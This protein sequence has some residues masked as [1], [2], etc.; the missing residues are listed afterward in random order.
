MMSLLVL[1]FEWLEQFHLYY[2]TVLLVRELSMEHYECDQ[3]GHKATCW[4]FHHH[5][6][7]IKCQST[8]IFFGGDA[9]NEN[10]INMC[11]LYN[12]SLVESCCLRQKYLLGMWVRLGDDFSEASFELDFWMPAW[13]AKFLCNHKERNQTVQVLANNQL[14]PC[15]VIT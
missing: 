10:K 4:D 7:R 8:W 15:G 2:T 12:Y 13:E 6:T 9:V 11:N 1:I 3:P 5:S 14:Q